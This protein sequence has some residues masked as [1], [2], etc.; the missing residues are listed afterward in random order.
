VPKRSQI[1]FDSAE[2]TL[3][4]RHNSFA[5]FDTLASIKMLRIAHQIICVNMGIAWR[6]VPTSGATIS[7]SAAVATLPSILRRWQSSNGA[8]AAQDVQESMDKVTPGYL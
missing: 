7:T 1:R 8:G 3:L 2:I 5:P 4:I 6:A